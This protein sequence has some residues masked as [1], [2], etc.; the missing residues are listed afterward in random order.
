MNAAISESD[1]ATK[2]RI[3]GVVLFGYTKNAQNRGK[4]DDFPSNKV[5]TY[6]ALTD[7]VCGGALLVTAGHFV[8]VSNGDADDAADFL[9]GQINGSTS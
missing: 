5:K 6:C 1:V 2:D 4:I 8:Y 9:A 3:L 7:G